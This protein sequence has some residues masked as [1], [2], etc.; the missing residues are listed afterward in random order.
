MTVHEDAIFVVGYSSRN[1][2]QY[3]NSPEMPKTVCIL[4][5]PVIRS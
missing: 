3:T 5:S 1:S 4:I 2:K